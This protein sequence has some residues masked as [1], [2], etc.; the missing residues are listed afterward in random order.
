[1]TNDVFAVWLKRN[2]FERMRVSLST[3]RFWI[4]LTLA[5]CLLTGLSRATETSFPPVDGEPLGTVSAGAI[6]LHDNWQM[7][8]EAI[9][10]NHGDTFSS[11]TFDAKDWYSATVP[12][13]A[14]A[15]LV[16]HGVYPDPI[17][18]M[19]M[20]KI[21][22]VNEA[23]NTRYD[24]LKYS[25]LPDHSN[26]FDRPYW[27]RTSFTLPASYQG[28]T[29]WLHLDGI[30]YRADVWLNGQQIANANDV[31]GMFKRF[32]FDISKLA[33][34]D[35]ASNT[36]AI[37]IHQLDVPGD[38]VLEQLGGVFGHLGPN[39]GDRQILANVSM[40]QSVG[41]DWTPS[42]R[43]RN[44][45]IWQHVWLEATG[46]V[47]VRDPAGF[48][49]VNWK[50]GQDAPIKV[51]GYLDNPGQQPVSTD[52]DVSIAP[53][54]FDGPTVEFK[55]NISAAS[56][57][58]EFILLPT[59]HPELVLHNPKVWWPDT[60]GDHPLYKLTVSAAVGGK[61]SSLA[62]SLLGVRTVG[63]YALA[64]GGRAFTCNGRTIRLSGGAWIPD[65]M[66]SWSA[67]RYRDEVRLM[68]EGNQTVVRVNGC[69]IMPPDVFFDSCDR[70]GLMVWE[71]F[72][73]SSPP[74]GGQA[75]PKVLMDNMV[76]CVDR[77]R[78]HPSLLL[79][80]GSNEVPAQSN[81]VQPMQDTVLPAMDG[82]RP[83][84]VT[85]NEAP[86]NPGGITMHS[87]G[88]YLQTPLR[89]LFY[90]YAHDP[91]FVC[92]NE[93]GMAAPMNINSVVQSIPDWDQTDD[94]NFPLNVSF[95]FHDATDG[96]YDATHRAIGQQFGPMP[97][98][99]E[100]LWL[101]DLYH[102]EFYRGV[103]EAANKARPRNAG[104]H[105]WK[106][107]ASWPSMVW[108]LFDW[109]LHTYSGYY[110]MKE[111]LKPVHVQYSI[112]DS[113]V[114]VVSTQPDALKGAKVHAEIVSLTGVT[115][116]TAD[117]TV[118]AA[119]DATTSAGSLADQFAN[120]HAHFLALTLTTA[121][122][123]VLDHDVRWVADDDVCWELQAL[124][125]ATV[126]GTVKD[127]HVDG[128]ETVD[129]VGIEN[130]SSLPALDVRSEILSGPQGGEVL[131][132]FWTD[133]ALNLMPHEKREVTVRYRTA[134]LAGA[135]PH[136]I[137]EGFNV[138]P[139]EINI[140]DGKVVP[141][142]IKLD[143]CET[144]PDRNDSPTVKLTYANTGTSGLRYTSWPI[145]L[146]VDGQ[147]VRYAHVDVSG[148]KETSQTVSFAGLLPGDHE[149]K[150]GFPDLAATQGS[151]KVTVA[152]LPTNLFVPPPVKALATSE[153]PG[154][155]VGHLFDGTLTPASIGTA[156]NL[157]GAYMAGSKDNAPLI[158]TD[159]GTAI[160]ARGL[161]F[162]QPPSSPPDAN[163]VTTINVWF[164]TTDPG[165][166][167]IP[168]STKNPKDKR[169]PDET[170]YIKWHTDATL[171]MFPFV[172]NRLGQFVIMQL[173]GH[174]ATVGG[175]ELR[176]I[177]Q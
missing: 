60:Y 164:L 21:P 135:E 162:A 91:N 72:S 73:R 148:S 81:W 133:N 147:V 2:T 47:A 98:L 137:I 36:L 100:Y 18:G 20:M 146:A 69:G 44:M 173:V 82:T 79:W 145:P 89:K 23:E 48:V 13:T 10:G 33:K 122:G 40:Y 61:P 138:M 65:T 115:E 160:K 62:S 108:E 93:I 3:T 41:W 64:S 152:P 29:V 110:Q 176:L 166:P 45:G 134:L 42:V 102:G 118:D 1:V 175:S 140:V 170:I 4:G 114:Q 168:N 30:N 17:M 56:G 67:Q 51:R 19:N 35:G 112:D 7:R 74:D 158:W 128:E 109:Y 86:R 94:K 77:M 116:A 129:T 131:P 39:C 54:G 113:G 92:K 97:D 132:S 78:S 165:G 9:A 90:L 154:M 174:R 172:H 123:K 85:S 6:V 105:L 144:A 141:L 63:T 68:A 143:T 57:R 159:Y 106:V 139:R 156:N 12:T 127:T 167:V 155:E 50:P 104:T 38:P 28:Q 119:A 121:D 99:M 153:T 32:R 34:T 126:V 169:P 27:F 150:A 157:G 55:Q 25:H 101:G 52:L 124:A 80:E 117:F 16:R 95:G 66:L 161:A 88:L 87:G 163:N 171:R 75:D 177:A 31:V 58:N 76:D 8:E 142:S 111:A 11:P 5:S 37:R 14:L 149:V 43:D 120:C 125:P 136:L 49:D 151:A 70:N 71:D 96:Y 15:T 107:N 26:P 130:T 84:T 24:L 46:P 53:E 103:Y 59:D 83:W 22:D